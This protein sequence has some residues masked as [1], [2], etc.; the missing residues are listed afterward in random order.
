LLLTIWQQRAGRI[1][2]RI[3]KHVGAPTLKVLL[4]GFPKIAPKRT[5]LP[6]FL[7]FLP[8][9]LHANIAMLPHLWYSI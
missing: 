7:P 9:L 2:R 4:E 6:A 3:P 5:C 8:Q 1:A